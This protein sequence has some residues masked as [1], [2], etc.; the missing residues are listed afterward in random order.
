MESN[1]KLQIISMAASLSVISLLLS[2]IFLFFFFK[3]PVFPALLTAIAIVA[4]LPLVV[5][6]NTLK[7]YCSWKGRMLEK[8][9]PEFDENWYGFAPLFRGRR[10]RNLGRLLEEKAGLRLYERGLKGHFYYPD[11]DR[12]WFN[13]FVSESVPYPEIAAV[14]TRK[15]TKGSFLIRLETVDF[16]VCYSFPLS[17]DEAERLASAVRGK[18]VRRFQIGRKNRPR[19]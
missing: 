19:P 9:G 16:K 14:D 2:A 3:D 8:F 7:N 13:I 5:V 12:T 18:A 6:W 15:L 4:L 11:E 17:E 10:S 1:K